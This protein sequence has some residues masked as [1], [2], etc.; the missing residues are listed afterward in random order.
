[1]TSI[2]QLPVATEA[3]T[4]NLRAMDIVARY[5]FLAAASTRIPYWWA[6]S[7]SV[8][9][10]Q[11]KMLSEVSDVYAVEFQQDLARPVIASIGGGLVN[12]FVSENPL[13]LALKAWIVTVPVVGLPLRFGVGPATVAAYTYVLGRAFVR[14]Y[15][16]GG[17]YHDFALHMF[18]SEAYRLVG[19]AP[20][21]PV[22]PWA[23]DDARPAAAF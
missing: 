20:P 22:A 8:T 6:T 19:L 17:S 2:D 14:H 18:R 4:R 16:A 10:L 1:V 7:P 3:S 5:T 13:T 23:V 21:G 15:D 11:L 9:A 12:L